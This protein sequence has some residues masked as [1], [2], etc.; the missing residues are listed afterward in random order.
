MENIETHFRIESIEGGCLGMYSNKQEFL[1]HCQG[2]KSLY[3]NS[4]FFERNKIFKWQN[5]DIKIKDFNIKFESILLESERININDRGNL[6][7]VS[8]IV[9][10]FIEYI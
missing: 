2:I 3:D 10:I 8:I 5:R 4:E 7:K 9:N 6:S 1:N